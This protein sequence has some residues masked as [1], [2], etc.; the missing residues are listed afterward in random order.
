MHR[1]RGIG[2]RPRLGRPRRGCHRAGQG[3]LRLQGVGRQGSPRRLAPGPWGRGPLGLIHERDQLQP[4]VPGRGS[5]SGGGSG[6]AEQAQARVTTARARSPA[7]QA[8]IGTLKSA[9]RIK[10]E[11]R[12]CNRIDGRT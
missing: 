8:L 3:P 4:G 10:L 11:H 9:K 2:P 7:D 5:A 6:N 12:R 1:H